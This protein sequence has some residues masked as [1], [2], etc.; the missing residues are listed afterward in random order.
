MTVQEFKDKLNKLGFPQKPSAYFDSKD[1]F[2]NKMNYKKDEKL[3]YHS[4][5][6]TE[7]LPVFLPKFGQ[8]FF[9]EHCLKNKLSRILAGELSTDTLQNKLSIEFCT[10]Y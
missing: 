10:Q 5:E 9:F 8:S 3:I 2:S 7:T 1:I 4:T 6:R